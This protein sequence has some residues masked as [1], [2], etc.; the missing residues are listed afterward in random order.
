MAFAGRAFTAD[1]EKRSA[2]AIAAGIGVVG[3]LGAGVIYLENEA[4]EK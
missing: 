2:A 3:L 4:T 1:P